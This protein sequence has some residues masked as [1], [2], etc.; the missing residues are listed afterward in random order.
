LPDLLDISYGRWAGRS[1]A[2]VSREEPELWRTLVERPHEMVFP[3]GESLAVV[4][5]RVMRALEAIRA[6]HPEEMVV[7][8]GHQLVNRVILCSVLD[9]GLQAYW[10]I[11]QETCCINQ[12]HYEDGIAYID[13]LNDTCHLTHLD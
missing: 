4:Q 5:E 6:W 12:F 1:V 8:V 9:L 3:E 10:R 11:G 7:V 2:D 13:R